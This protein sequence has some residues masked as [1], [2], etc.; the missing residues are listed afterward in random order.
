MGSVCKTKKIL[1]TESLG[2]TKSTID[3]GISMGIQPSTDDL[4]ET[5]RHYVQEGY[6][7]NK[8][9]IKPSWD[10]EVLQVVR[11]H[12]LDTPIM[13]DAN[14]AYTLADTNLLSLGLRTARPTENICP[15]KMDVAV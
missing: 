12:F 8:L 15:S 3:V 5:V 14:S 13:A 7:R 11:K 4:I 6:K 9:K 10:V 2:G 1:L